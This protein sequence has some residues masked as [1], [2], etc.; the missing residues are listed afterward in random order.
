MKFLVRM[1]A[2]VAPLL[3]GPA[4]ADDDPAYDR[5]FLMPN[6]STLGAG[7]EAGYRVNESWQVRAGINGG[8]LSF[9]YKDKDSDLH[10]RA[11]LLSGGVTVD[12]FPFEGDFYLSGGVRLSANKIEGKVKN[13]HGKLKGGGNVFVPDPLTSFTVKQNT[14]QPYLGA[15]YSVK[16]KQG[17]S[18]NFDLG[19]LYAGTPDLDVNSRA[20]TL[21]FS[22]RD[23][24]REI[25]RAQNR[26]AP[27]KVYPVVQVGLKFEF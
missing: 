18:L 8:A 3:A 15:G 12:Y 25:E 11:T 22:R 6:I 5:F 23:I 9:V 19:A 13:L 14:I 1:L 20:H 2:I 7:I 17:V 21:G 10:S 16:I 27:F 4:L 24:R 26:I